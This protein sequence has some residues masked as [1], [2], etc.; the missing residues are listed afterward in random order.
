MSNKLGNRFNSDGNDMMA[1]M[2]LY[3]HMKNDSRDNGINMFDANEELVNGSNM[4]SHF[5]K[6]IKKHII[7]TKSN[8]QIIPV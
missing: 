1:V 7:I 3:N 2:E 6:F 8:D 5:Y 4:F